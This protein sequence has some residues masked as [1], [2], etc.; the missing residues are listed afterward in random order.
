MQTLSRA[1]VV[2]VAALCS[3]HAAAQTCS[4]PPDWPVTT[5]DL[6]PFC[7]DQPAS[8]EAVNG[9][10]ASLA[11]AILRKGGPFNE[12]FNPDGGVVLTRHLN[13]GAVTTPKLGPGAVD[14]TKLAPSAVQTN[15][16]ANGAVTRAKVVDGGVAIYSNN[17]TCGNA[18]QLT[19]DSTCL[20]PT[21]T[22]GTCNLPSVPVYWSCDGRCQNQTPSCQTAPVFCPAPNTLRG[23]LVP[24]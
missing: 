24:P 5:M 22:C 4:A 3:S 18:G 9:N 13:D 12:G 15:N 19:L 23:Y 14:S 2:V 17:T 20:A 11:R 16:L 6:K 8:A 7:A 1:V 10:F 21:T